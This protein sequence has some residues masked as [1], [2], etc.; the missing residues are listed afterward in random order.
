[1]S[2]NLWFV[3]F[4]SCIQPPPRTRPALPPSPI[5]F[6]IRFSSARASSP[7]AGGGVLRS[8]SLHRCARRSLHARIPRQAKEI[9]DMVVFTPFHQ[10][11]ARESAVTANNDSCRCSTGE[12]LPPTDSLPGTCR[13]ADSSSCCRNCGRHRPSWFTWIGSSVASTSMMSCPGSPS[14]L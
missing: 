10:P 7:P 8:G 11:L 4:F 1:M 5:P 14:P 3:L 2:G 13:A 12:A 9:I 6:S